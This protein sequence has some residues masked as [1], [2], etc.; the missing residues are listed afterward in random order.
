MLH[1][2]I[3]QAAYFEAVTNAGPDEI[4]RWAL[5]KTAQV[6]DAALL[7]FPSES[8]VVARVEILS[9]PEPGNFGKASVY[10]A[11]VGKVMALG[12]RV[13]IEELKA[14]FGDWG[15]PRYP[16]TYTSVP[17][18]QP[19]HAD[20]RMVERVDGRRHPRAAPNEHVDS[21]SG[22]PETLTNR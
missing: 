9:P 20:S 22:C 2:L 16:R 21:C 12:R 4:F 18:A 8:A 17:G 13:T 15:W 10:L 7:Y 3:G 14:K 11:D 19:R 5:P 1:I 6:G